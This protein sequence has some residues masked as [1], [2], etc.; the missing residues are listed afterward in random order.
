MAKNDAQADSGDELAAPKRGKRL[1]RLVL[2]TILL[3]CI[4]VG[5]YIGAA[6]MMKLPPFEPTGPT[7]EEIAA[8][9]AAKQAAE[10]ERTRDIYVSFDQPFTFN[11]DYGGRAHTAQI[12]AVLVVAGPANEKLA[13]KH[14]ALLNSTMLGILSQQSYNGLLMPSGRE[15]LKI[16]LLDALRGKMSEVAGSPVIEQ[17]LITGFVM[18]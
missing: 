7:P 6:Y 9:K 8:Q 17:V 1:M 3:L 18:Q 14:L 5:G 13:K 15:R 16:E 10:A 2:V 4:L 12:E 11:L